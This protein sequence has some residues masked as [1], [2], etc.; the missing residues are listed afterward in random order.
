MTRAAHIG[1]VTLALTDAGAWQH[2]ATCSC[3]FKSDP[4]WQEDYAT[5]ALRDHLASLPP[6][7][8]E[9]RT[10]DEWLLLAL[11]PIREQIL[12]SEDGTELV[13]IGSRLTEIEQK[14]STS[15]AEI[16]RLLN[17]RLSHVTGRV[18]GQG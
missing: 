13:F 11:D 5:R 16:R 12:Q 10:I 6:V 9:I 14:I 4:Y 2:V 7:E 18:K 8:E 17:E 3:G 1:S 15:F